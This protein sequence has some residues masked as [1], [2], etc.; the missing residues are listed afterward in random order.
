VRK[1]LWSCWLQGRERAPWLVR[2]CLS[3]WE[4]RNPDWELR[5][6][7][8]RSLPRWV[9]LPDLAG[10]RITRASFS[11]IA[12]V[13]LLQEYGGIWVD[14]TVFCHRPLS[15]WFGAAFTHGFF[16]FDR[17]GGDRP[18]A[19]W[20][21]A[22]EEG[23]YLTD[24]W[25]SAT[26][27]Y[28]AARDRSDDYFWFHHLFGALC[29][30]DP[31]FARTWDAVP[32]ISADAPHAIQAAGLAQTDRPTIDRLVD[33]SAPVFKLTHRF[34]TRE[35]GPGTL[36]A[37]LLGP[38][39]REAEAAPDEDERAAAAPAAAPP[40]AALAVSTNNLGD[41]LQILAGLRMLRRLGVVPAHVVDRDD[42]IA[43]CDAL[44]PGESRVPILLNGWFKT[45][46]AQWPPHARLSPLFFGFHI[47]LWQC[48]ELLSDVALAYYRRHA[49][50]GCRDPHTHDL[51]RA[52]GVECFVSGCLTLS[53]A[54]RRNAEV[55]GDTV[56]VSSRDRRILDILPR[57]L[58][59][60]RYVNHYSDSAD[61]GTNLE[62]A[63]AL[64]ETYRQ[65]ARLVV[66]TFL[67]CALPAIAMGIPVVVFYPDQD[68]A[69]HQSDR[70]RFSA[71][72]D[73]VPIH[74][75]RHVDRVDWRPRP[76]A[77]ADLKIAMLD[78]FFALAERWALPAAPE[79][80]PFAESRELPPPA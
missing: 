55:R 45:N 47:R 20:F 65:E 39:P 18:V 40:F 14:A 51:L 3:S 13:L 43:S 80:G 67:H 66:T 26:L 16:A 71:L 1:V 21:L 74:S 44:P 48:P 34:D 23:H 2:R 25:C 60:Y 38:A 42:D 35:C 77:T 7:D 11:D 41:H 76:I 79:V 64:L 4:E 52:R 54:R 57:A 37:E 15:D 33:W 63:A 62:R 69:A 59:P 5:C 24:A 31:A 50:V 28:W 19:S 29:K 53:F 27:A 9:D 78:R 36:L 32:R 49:P 17:P 61:F 12:R 75:F 70:E 72:E 10:K 46:R 6:L 58:G 22:S 8:R 68:G 73:L 30:S 56:F